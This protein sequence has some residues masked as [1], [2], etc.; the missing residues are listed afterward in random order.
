[1]AGVVAEAA[2]AVVA[3]LAAEWHAAALM[4]GCRAAASLVAG[5]ARAARGGTALI[6]TVPAIG[7]ALA[8]IGAAITAVAETGMVIIGTAITGIMGIIITAMM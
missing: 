2:V 7:T 6:G 3:A 1:M 5:W 4:A 8:I